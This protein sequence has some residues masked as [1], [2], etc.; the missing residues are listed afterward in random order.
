MEVFLNERKVRVN[1]EIGRWAT[2]GGLGVLVVGMVVSIRNPGLVIVSMGSLLVGFL[3]SVVGA[4]YANHWTRTPRADEV[5]SQS[6]KG[7]SN[8]YHLYHYLLP[9]PHV[10]LGPAGIFVLRA[11]LHEGPVTYDGDKW[12]H[13][14]S[15]VQ[16]LGFSGQDA[17]GDPVRD[18]NYDVQ[19]LRNWLVKRLPED[20]IPPIAPFIVFVRD[21]AQLDVVDTPVPVVGH[22]QLKNRIRKI[23]KECAEPLD[24]DALYEVERGMLGPRIDE[25]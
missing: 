14:R 25:L 22:K 18:A 8:R 7:I 5:L 2:L 23:D 10:L 12:R 1:T 9:V 15:F 4:Y 16:R 3:A 13:K 11:Y 17:L 6:L 20:D 21:G 24:D 19:R